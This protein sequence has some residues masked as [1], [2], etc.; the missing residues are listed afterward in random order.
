LLVRLQRSCVLLFLQT[1]RFC[2]VMFSSS[3]FIAFYLPSRPLAQ[4]SYEQT[5]MP[6]AA[7]HRLQPRSSCPAPR[8]RPCVSCATQAAAAGRTPRSKSFAR[9]SNSCFKRATATHATGRNHGSLAEVCNAR[10]SLGVITRPLQHQ[11]LRPWPR[12]PSE[13]HATH[14]KNGETRFTCEG[15]GRGLLESLSCHATRWQQRRRCAATCSHR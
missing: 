12:L 8:P 5:R 6:S 1:W 9:V 4:F 10:V 7:A 15:E 11:H 14:N 13:H 2:D 3:K